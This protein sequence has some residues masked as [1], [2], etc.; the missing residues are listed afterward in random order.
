MKLHSTLLLSIL[1]SV[2]VTGCWGPL[3]GDGVCAFGENC[4]IDCRTLYD[5]T[6]SWRD[7]SQNEDGFEIERRNDDQGFSRIASVDEDATSY[8]DEALEEGSIYEYR[9]RGYHQDPYTT[10]EYSNTAVADLSTS[11]GELAEPSA[12]EELAAIVSNANEN[13]TPENLEAVVDYARN[14]QER[15]IRELASNPRALYDE[16]IPEDVKRSLPAK[17]REFIEQPVNLRGRVEVITFDD[18]DKNRT[19]TLHFSL[20]RCLSSAQ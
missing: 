20:W 13:P 4:D 18:F 10:S 19:V 7:N 2:L 14:R 12:V 6:L 16:I 3:C 15:I 9:V 11:P 5:A 17:A 1:M 8:L